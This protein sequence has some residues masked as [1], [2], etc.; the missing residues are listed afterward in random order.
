VTK[1]ETLVGLQE[2]FDALPDEAN[3]EVVSLRVRTPPNAGHTIVVCDPAYAA[4]E[5]ARGRKRRRRAA[6][7]AKRRTPR[8]SAR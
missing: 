3:V 8:G 1:A 7:S 4:R 5:D 6:R 2:V